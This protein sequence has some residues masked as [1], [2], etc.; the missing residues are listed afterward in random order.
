MTVV[1]SLPSKD[2]KE[3]DQAPLVNLNAMSPPPSYNPKAL[4]AGERTNRNKR[5][6]TR[7]NNTKGPYFSFL[8]VLLMI[9]VLFV[10]ST[11]VPICRSYNEFLNRYPHGSNTVRYRKLY[12]MHPA[13]GNDMMGPVIK[14][15]SQCDCDAEEERS[16]VV[17]AEATKKKPETS[18][19]EEGAVF[20]TVTVPFQAAAAD[21]PGAAASTAIPDGVAAVAPGT[22]DDNDDGKP[23]PVNVTKTARFIHDFS[24]NITGIV[25]VEAH[26]C[27]IMPFFHDSNAP[28]SMDELMFKMTSSSYEL[29]MKKVTSTM[30]MVQPAL[31]DLS[32]FGLYISNDCAD[33]PTYRLEKADVVGL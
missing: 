27:Y 28:V 10:L 32:A 18:A 4:E 9:A 14:C 26:C 1:T 24:V 2:P 8:M 33:Y 7:P 6:S 3:S 17:E 16:E 5:E 12:K 22:D 13:T 23:Q 20:A 31:T 15:A 30:R 11:F 25:D 21:Y 19:A 29:E